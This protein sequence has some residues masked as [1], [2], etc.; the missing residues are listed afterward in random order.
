MAS[1]VSGT[2][3]CWPVPVVK[4]TSQRSGTCWGR[5]SPSRPPKRRP[6]RSRSPF[7]SRVPVAVGR[8]GSP[9][10]SSAVRRRDHGHR[11]GSRPHDETPIP[12]PDPQRVPA[13][14]LHGLVLL[15]AEQ[16][17]KSLRPLHALQARSTEDWR[18]RPSCHRA[19]RTQVAALVQGGSF[20][21]RTFPI[22]SASHPAASS[23]QG[24]STWTATT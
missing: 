8:C 4:P 16:F 7:A 14:D 3:A 12:Q 11:R 9:R 1:T 2:T 21:R 24:L 20:L 23:F 17:A 15:S 10:S 6:S 13:R 5:R 18:K 19:I 22:D